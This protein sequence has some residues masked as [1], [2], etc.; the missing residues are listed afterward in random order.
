ME[1]AKRGRHCAQWWADTEECAVG[2]S[3]S[4]SRDG[5]E[6]TRKGLGTE[7][8]ISRKGLEMEAEAGKDASRGLAEGAAY[9]GVLEKESSGVDSL[10]SPASQSEGD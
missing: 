10:Y 5:G 8:K 1:G 4:R 6:D 3:A 2:Y 7:A 9:G